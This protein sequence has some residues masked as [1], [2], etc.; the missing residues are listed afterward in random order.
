MQPLFRKNAVDQISS[1]EQLNDYVRVPSRGVW[2][3]LMSILL[4]VSSFLVWGML[5]RIQTKLGV[6]AYAQDGAVSCFLT[7]EAYEAIS[8][9]AVSVFIGGREYALDKASIKAV[10]GGA[11][12]ARYAGNEALLG[13]LNPAE[14]TPLYQAETRVPDGPDGMADA[15]IVIRSVSPLSFAFD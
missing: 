2:L 12:R 3:A 6:V 8:S 15:Q 13:A 7:Q 9:G 1:P 4:L 5:G 14:G 11:L 10:D